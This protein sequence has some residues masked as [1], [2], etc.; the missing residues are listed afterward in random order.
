MVLRNPDRARERLTPSTRRLGVESPEEVQDGPELDRR[1]HDAEYDR[2]P[3]V[4]PGLCLIFLEGA[5]R[6]IHAEC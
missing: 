4:P 5:R 3:Q 2:R 1:G 6:A